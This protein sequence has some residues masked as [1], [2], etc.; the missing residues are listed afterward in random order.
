VSCNLFKVSL[1]LLEA[2]NLPVLMMHLRTPSPQA[3][4]KK[5]KKEDTSNQ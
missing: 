5:D 1:K 3:I 4:T 2:K